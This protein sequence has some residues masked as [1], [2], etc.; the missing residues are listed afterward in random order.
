[1]PLSVNLSWKIRN[2]K[3]LL[4][5]KDLSIY[6]VASIVVWLLTG[7]W[8]GANYT[9][10]MWGIIHGFFLVIYKGQMKPRKKVF[11]KLGINNKNIIVV[12]TETII[13]LCIV[14]MA[15][16]FFRADN[17]REAIFY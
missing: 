13:T 14:I 9:F 3:N 12:I 7:L 4:I 10:I 15:W 17:I 16:I 8:H 6:I 5:S 1:L 11:K 2:E